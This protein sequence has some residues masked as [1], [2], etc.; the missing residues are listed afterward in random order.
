MYPEDDQLPGQALPDAYPTAAP[1]AMPPTAAPGQGPLAAPT[2]AP[3]QLPGSAPLPSLRDVWGARGGAREG[4]AGQGDLEGRMNEMAGRLGWSRGEAGADGKPGSWSW[5]PSKMNLLGH[6]GAPG[7]PGMGHRRHG[8]MHG[9]H[10]GMHGERVSNM[11]MPRGFAAHLPWGRP[12][13]KTPAAPVAGAPAAAPGATPA[14]TPGAA[15]V[16]AE[17]NDELERG[18]Q[19]PRRWSF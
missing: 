2:T 7:M 15:P 12:A 18:Q 4:R 8:G 11:Q 13:P 1:A 17:R 10:G 14:V 3:V 16:R 6:G 5:D 9:E 19:G